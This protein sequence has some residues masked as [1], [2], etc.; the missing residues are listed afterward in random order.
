[1]AFSGGVA[2]CVRGSVM[3]GILGGRGFREGRGFGMGGAFILGRCFERGVASWGRGFHVVGMGLGSTGGR[4][5]YG[6]GS[7][8]GAGLREGRGF[9]GRGFGIGRGFTAGDSLVGRAV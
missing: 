5:F 3:D 9:C 6:R 8:D 4:G 2:F 1:M 7:R